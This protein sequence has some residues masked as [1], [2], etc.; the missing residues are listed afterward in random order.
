MDEPSLVTPCYS[1]LMFP[2]SI[3]HVTSTVTDG[4]FC[5]RFGDKAAE[6]LITRS[7][8]LKKHD[9]QP[10]QVCLM[11]V[12]HGAE[13]F[14]VTAENFDPT[15]NPICDVLVTKEPNLSFN[16]THC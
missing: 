12:E 6:Y 5:L 14:E 9:I 11:Q 3:V 7:T 1:T 13:I 4:N 8:W 10:K 15:T 2:S 16:A